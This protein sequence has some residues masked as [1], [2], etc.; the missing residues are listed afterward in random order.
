MRLPEKDGATGGVNVKTVLLPS[1]LELN[2][3]MSPGIAE[4]TRKLLTPADVVPTAG[5]EIFVR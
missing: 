3:A 1:V 4:L 5:V 2:P